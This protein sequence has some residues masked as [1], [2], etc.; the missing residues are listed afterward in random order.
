[1][2]DYKG[3]PAFSL[4]S[5]G[6]AEGV[7]LPAEVEFTLI[8]GAPAGLEWDMLSE[9]EY[10]PLWFL[11]EAVD[12]ELGDD[13]AQDLISPVC[14]ATVDPNTGKACMSIGSSCCHDKKFT[15]P[16][17]TPGVNIVISE[18]QAALGTSETSMARLSH[19]AVLP[20][21]GPPASLMKMAR[22]AD[23]NIQSCFQQLLG[24]GVFKLKFYCDN[25]DTLHLTVLAFLKL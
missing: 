7:S 11:G 15:V 6:V 24:K 18:L 2:R 23:F 9:N 10:G 3:L 21:L 12:Y 8:N 22:H 17:Y 19:E 16:N 25:N 5:W 4:E 1:M 20:I 14:R 13:Q